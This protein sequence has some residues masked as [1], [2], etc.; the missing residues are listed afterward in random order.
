[1]HLIL[2]GNDVFIAIQATLDFKLETS[3]F[4]D[5][6]L[7]LTVEKNQQSKS[8]TRNP[9]SSLS[10]KPLKNG[11][12]QPNTKVRKLRKRIKKSK[13]NLKNK[14]TPTKGI[15]TYSSHTQKIKKRKSLAA[16]MLAITILFSSGGLVIALSWISILFMFNPLSVSWLNPFLPESSKINCITASLI[17]LEFSDNKSGNIFLIK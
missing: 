11:K 13:K 3:I 12:A 7:V 10:S 2:V 17:E 9:K 5:P 8:K 15:R 6:N 4:Y 16:S 1:M 14:N